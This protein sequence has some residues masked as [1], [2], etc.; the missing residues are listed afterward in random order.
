V[1]SRNEEELK[2]QAANAEYQYAAH[3]CKISIEPEE[4]YKRISKNTGPKYGPM[5][6]PLTNIS[7]S[8]DGLGHTAILLYRTYRDSA[9]TTPERFTVHPSTLDGIF[10][11]TYLGLAKG[12]SEPMPTLVLSRLTRLWISEAGVGHIELGSEVANSSSSFISKRT[13]V[14]K[15]RVFSQVDMSTRLELEGL[16]VT[17]IV[18]LQDFSLEVPISQPIC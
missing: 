4:L 13:V 14:G 11:F 18:G 10:Q 12:W 17:E 15:I 3:A 6:R 2:Q 7:Y 9:Y 8:S 5:L 16:E 1:D